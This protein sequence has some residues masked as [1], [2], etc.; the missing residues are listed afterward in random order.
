MTGTL[1]K[2]LEER[3]CMWNS[4]TELAS[5]NFK[6]IKICFYVQQKVRDEKRIGPTGQY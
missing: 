4:D 5:K 1:K 3:C 6:Y 2:I